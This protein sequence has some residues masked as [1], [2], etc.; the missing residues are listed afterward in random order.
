MG[1]G[2]PT[3][4]QTLPYSLVAL[5]SDSALALYAYYWHMY[6]YYYMQHE[7]YKHT[8]PAEFTR[9]TAKDKPTTLAIA[10]DTV[11]ILLAAILRL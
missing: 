6:L 2:P 3:F 10:E 8:F 9:G 1:T 4:F 7:E 5:A 11:F